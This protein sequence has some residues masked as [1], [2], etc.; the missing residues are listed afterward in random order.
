MS[1][2]PVETNAT[3]M[4]IASETTAQTA[5]GR[6]PEIESPSNLYFI[7]PISRA[8]AGG[9]ARTPVTP[10]QVSVSGL[11]AAG[12]AGLCYLELPW[13]WNAFVG[14]AFHL[15]W[16]VLDG[17]DG[18]LARRTGRASPIGELVDGVCDH[19]GQF[20]IYI[21]L[22]YLAMRHLGS[23]VWGVAWAAGAAHF[24][25]ANAYET[26]RKAYRRFVYG[27]A[28]MR[29]T[30]AGKRGVGALLASIYLGFSDL[31]SPGEATVEQAMAAAPPELGRR[32]YREAFQPLV[33]AS[34]VLSMNTRTFAV[35]VAVLIQRPLW[36]FLFEL[37]VLNLA[38]V[39][40]AV[41]RA[42]TSAA[43]AAALA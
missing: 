16:H 38:L 9:L 4:S 20:L 5:P 21:P 17:A 27:A 11:V 6:P 3:V 43:L 18:D 12:T 42:R 14:F 19:A 28:W 33:K 40:L 35:F 30:G 41:W 26:A 23:W 13:P 39:V 31:L 8:L 32:L 37:T 29:Q 10:N 36:F 25:Q 1:K 24:L 2:P 22:V 7:H 34:S 15:G